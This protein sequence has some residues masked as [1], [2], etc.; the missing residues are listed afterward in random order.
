[1]QRQ[2]QNTGKHE[3]P[4]QGGLGASGPLQLDGEQQIL[5]VIGNQPRAIKQGKHQKQRV[6]QNRGEAGQERFA[7]GRIHGG[8]DNR[9]AD[10]QNPKNPGCNETHDIKTTA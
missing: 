2:H 10:K 8:D 9:M 7:G 5:L 6:T 4:P 1:M 3:H